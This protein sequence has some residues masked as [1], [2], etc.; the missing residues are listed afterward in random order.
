[1]AKSVLLSLNIMHTAIGTHISIVGGIA[2]VSVASI[3]TIL[4]SQVLFFLLDYSG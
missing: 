1:M 2:L 3:E 4:L